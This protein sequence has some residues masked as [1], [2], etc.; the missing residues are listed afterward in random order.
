MELVGS[1]AA[2]ESSYWRFFFSRIYALPNETRRA[3]I[4]RIADVQR[5][6]MDSDFGEGTSQILVCN[7]QQILSSLGAEAIFAGR[8]KDILVIACFD[9]LGRRLPRLLLVSE[10]PCCD[11][12]LAHPHTRT[13]PGPT[14]HPTQQPV[15]RKKQFAVA[16][17]YRRRRSRTY[18]LRVA[19]PASR[20]SSSQPALLTARGTVDPGSPIAPS[21]GISRLSHC[22]LRRLMSEPL[23]GP[24]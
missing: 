18:S 13:R 7:S 11:A 23:P 20:A 5:M 16:R 6:H 1:G 21:V 9:E 19:P 10:W 3:P 8:C 24:W 12:G 15:P 14:P 22:L 2:G 17:L 4:H